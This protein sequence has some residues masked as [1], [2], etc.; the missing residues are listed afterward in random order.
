MEIRTI[1]IDLGKTVFHL[2][3]VNARGEVVV[4]KKCSRTQLLRF[5]SNLRKCLIGMEACG[6]SHFLG[7]AL[8]EQGH[9]VRLMP[10]QY[11]KPYVKTNKNDYIDD[12]VCAEAVTRPTMR[13]VPIKTD[14]QLD[15]QSLHRVRERWVGR[16]TAV[17]NQ[18]RGLLLE[19][20]ITIRKGRH[21]IEESLPRILE[22][23]DNKLSGALR[24]LLTQLRLE[25]QYLH[26]QVEESDKLIERI[27]G[28]LEPCRRLIAIPGI[29]PI[30]ATE[31]HNNRHHGIRSVASVLP[32][33]L[34]AGP[35]APAGALLAGREVFVPLTHV[36]ANV[37]LVCRTFTEVIR[38]FI[39]AGNV[40][41][42]FKNVAYHAAPV[43]LAD[44]DGEFQSCCLPIHSARINPNILRMNANTP[45]MRRAKSCKI[46]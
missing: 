2:A 17:I 35:R 26:G 43:G 15:L 31:P 29:G 3:G 37:N 33:G 9:D 6:G 42:I 32:V 13:F 11:V 19:R 18:I 23:P 28:E 1:G 7:R 36:N 5:T 14:D 16:R 25:M 40:H 10:A 45:Q 24:V 21:H 22:D 8:R 12:E 4:V 30:T 46:A 44:N 38:T 27:A 34:Y 41:G 20:G 39:F